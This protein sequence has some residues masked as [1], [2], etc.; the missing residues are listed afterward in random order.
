[1]ARLFGRV[2]VSERPPSQGV[3]G[4]PAAGFCEAAAGGTAG[5]AGRGDVGSWTFS[6]SGERLRGPRADDSTWL[7]SIDDE[8][9]MVIS[10]FGILEN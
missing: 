1:M 5:S 9:S 4:G 8:G 3:S 7:V 10:L 6:L 2:A